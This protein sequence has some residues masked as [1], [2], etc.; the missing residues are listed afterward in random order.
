MYHELISHFQDAK[1]SVLMKSTPY[2]NKPLVIGLE[3]PQAHMICISTPCSSYVK[4]M[5]RMIRNAGTI[6]A[7]ARPNNTRTT[8]REA[9]LL[10]GTCSKRMAPLNFEEC[11]G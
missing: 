5:D 8:M 4:N 1:L 6:H 10:Q 9:K 2:D 7:S 3:F 11:Q